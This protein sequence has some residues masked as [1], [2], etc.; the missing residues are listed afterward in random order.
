M[1]CLSLFV[2]VTGHTVMFCLSLLMLLD[3][4]ETISYVLFVIVC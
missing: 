2:D 4:Q 3:I 1:F